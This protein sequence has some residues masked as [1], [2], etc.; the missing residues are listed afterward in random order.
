MNIVDFGKNT[1][2]HQIDFRFDCLTGDVTRRLVE[3]FLVRSKRFQS[4]SKPSGQGETLLATGSGKPDSP[5]FQLKLSPSQ[6]ILWGGWYTHFD[7]WTDSSKSVL[8]ELSELLE[9]PVQFANSLTSSLTV[10]VPRNQLKPPSEMPDYA[11]LRKKLSEFLPDEF[12][13]RVSGISSSWDGTGN[14][15]LDWWA[16][17]GA[18]P[19][20]VNH[21]LGLFR[22][23]SEA[24]GNLK[25]VVVS[26]LD[27]FAIALEKYHAGHLSRIIKR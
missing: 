7:T 3:H 1:Y 22:N 18:N 21:T 24:D 5:I 4:V 25:A 19:D 8:S 9:I 16:I 13:D 27:D 17:P 2:Q 15:R 20:E 10:L 14:R 6:A 11:F 12:L 26:Q 23:V